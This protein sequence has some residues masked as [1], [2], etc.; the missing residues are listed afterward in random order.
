MSYPTRRHT[1]T[2]FC[3]GISRHP[4]W[5]LAFLDTSERLFLAWTDNSVVS[6]ED[7]DATIEAALGLKSP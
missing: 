1:E 7:D 5:E 3:T 2:G 6:A 4:N